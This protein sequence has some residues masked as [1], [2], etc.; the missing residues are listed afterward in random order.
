MLN[1]VRLAVI[2]T[3]TQN[4]VFVPLIVFCVTPHGAPDY[5]LQTHVYISQM[6]QPSHQNSFLTLTGFVI[7][8]L[9]KLTFAEVVL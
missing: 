9:P 1:Q 7:R 2:I 3:G 4:D 6:F 8:L 5:D